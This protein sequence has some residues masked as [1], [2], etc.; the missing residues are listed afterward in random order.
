[1]FHSNNKPRAIIYGG[2]YNPEQWSEAI[3]LEDAVRMQ[4]AGVNLVSLGV[5]A[6]SRLEPAPHEYA[7]DWL[8]SVMDL[9]HA[10]GVAVN[11]A[12]ATASPPPW[13][14]KHHPESLPTKADGTRLGIGSRQAYCPSNPDFRHAASRLTTALATRYATHPALAMWHIGNEY[15]CHVSQCFCQTCAAAFR[16]WLERR[17]GSLD[18]LNTAWCSDFWSQRYAAWDEI[19]PPRQTPY[20]KNPTQDLD[21]QRFCSDNLLE[22]FRLEQDIVRQHTPNI[23]VATNFMGF[24]KPLDYWAW[25]EHQDLIANDTYPDPS[26]PDA[27]IE[28]AMNADLMRSLG[29]GKPW[30]IMEQVTGQVQWRER[31]ALKRPQQMR[32]WSYQAIARG[33]SGIMFFQWRASRGGA[34]RF[35]GAMLPHAGTNSRIWREVVALGQELR[36]LEL[37]ETAPHAEIALLL[38]WEN[39]WA[40]EGEGHP[41]KMALLPLLKSWYSVLYR[42]NLVVDF[43]HPMHD[44]S[45]YKTVLTPNLHLLGSEAAANLEHYVASGGTLLVGAYSGIVDHNV[46]VHLPGYAAVLH[47]LLG[48]RVEEFDV[49]PE[50]ATINLTTTTGQVLAATQWSEAI[51]C[52]GAEP[53]AHFADSRPAIT[54]HPFGLG[55]AFYLGT[56]LEEAGLAWLIGLVL[57]H[58]QINPA[59]HP[60]GLE[61]VVRSANGWRIEFW[62]NHQAQAVELQA[63]GRCLLTQRAIAGAVQ[64]EPYGVLMLE[65]KEQGGL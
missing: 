27:H 33:A 8:D 26:L 40:L 45:R 3:W 31:N 4:Q 19:Q 42:H 1:M 20:M 30:L 18:A 51:D 49:L 56:Q 10:H 14:A 12:T 55:K 50:L 22:C 64:L 59:T 7:F 53:L 17:Y 43:A 52:V 63:N 41:L 6:W 38:D 47:R 23:P 29:R 5:F 48:L 39:W 36:Q 35:H 62:F 15:G 13:L 57:Q 46:Q 58:A 65:Q 60:S 32:L 61:C 16:L 24:F 25:A 2:D 28:A 54:Q 34:E 21:W 9:L 37:G 44:L 11:L